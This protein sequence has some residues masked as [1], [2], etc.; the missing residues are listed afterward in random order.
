VGAAIALYPRGIST[1]VRLYAEPP[2]TPLHRL[3]HHAHTARAHVG[4]FVGTLGLAV[5]ALPAAWQF[6]FALVGV[7]AVRAA[8][9]WKG[10]GALVDRT[11]EKKEEGGEGGDDEPEEE[12]R[13]DARCVWRVL[14]GEEEKEIL[15]ACGDGGGG[16]VV[17]D[18]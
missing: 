12:W 9:V 11:E 5:A 1:L 15:R 13:E 18:E 8:V 7:V 17:K 6:R 16:V 4:I 14:R 2:R 10:F 3:A